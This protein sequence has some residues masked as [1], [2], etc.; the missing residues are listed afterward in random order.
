MDVLYEYLTEGTHSTNWNDAVRANTRNSHYSI[1]GGSVGQRP[2]ILDTSLSVGALAREE[3]LQKAPKILPFELSRLPEHYA[4]VY[5]HMKRSKNAL[6]NAYS[7]GLLNSDK[8]DMIKSQMKK[9]SKMMKGL[10]EMAIE[11]DKLSF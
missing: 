3:Q 1:N 10:R 9:F 4:D 11:I 7:S 6:Q 5:L 2:S 8:K